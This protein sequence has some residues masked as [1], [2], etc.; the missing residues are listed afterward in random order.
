MSIFLNASSRIR[1]SAMSAATIK[2]GA[3]VIVIRMRFLS[4]LFLFFKVSAVFHHQSNKSII[5]GLHVS[6]GTCENN[7]SCGKDQKSVFGIFFAFF[8]DKVLVVFIVH[9]TA[10]NLV[11]GFRTLDGQQF[12][13]CGRHRDFDVYSRVH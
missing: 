3:E 1:T 13:V 10:H 9:L 6:T 5:N 2:L 7:V 11:G 12:A 4:T 8:H